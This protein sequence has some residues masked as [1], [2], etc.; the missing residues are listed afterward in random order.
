MIY[1]EKIKAKKSDKMIKIWMS[2]SIIV[3]IILFII[4][5]LTTPNIPWAA[6]AN[7]RYFI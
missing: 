7:S 2:V 1:P 6:L 5:K 3:A 4:N